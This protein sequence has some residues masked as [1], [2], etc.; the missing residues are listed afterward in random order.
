MRH[1]FKEMIDQ[2]N[3]HITNIKLSVPKSSW[4]VA[5]KW[6]NFSVYN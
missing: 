6:G 4:S 2:G 3:V 5:I 1:R